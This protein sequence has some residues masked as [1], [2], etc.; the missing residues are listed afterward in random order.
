MRMTTFRVALPVLLVFTAACG[1][2]DP[3]NPGPN[4]ATIPVVSGM[5][6][7]SSVNQDPSCDATI[8]AG[9]LVDGPA[10]DNG[11]MEVKQNAGAVDMEITELAGQ[12]FS[13]AEADALS[14]VGTIDTTGTGMITRSLA[15]QDTAT[16]DSTVYFV[17]Q[18]TE[19]TVAFTVNGTTRTLSSAITFTS[20]YR[21][22]S[23][24]APLFA[25]CTTT[26]TITG[27]SN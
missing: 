2:D 19:G 11:Q 18:E 25:T 21:P 12:M 26:G 6:S 5:Y 4:P 13:A 14:L 8:P 20:E 3:M 17:S 27:S 7:I 15:R 24:T 10:N 22:D 1:D 9:V 16:A 23:A